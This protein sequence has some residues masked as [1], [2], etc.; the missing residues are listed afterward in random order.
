[1]NNEIKPFAAFTYKAP[2]GEIDTAT[3]NNNI[4]TLANDKNT[5]S[6]AELKDFKKEFA[7]TAQQLENTPLKDEVSFNKNEEAVINQK[8]QYKKPNIGT[9]IAGILAGR[10]VN[11]LTTN[12]PKNIISSKAFEE[13]AKLSDGLSK[14]EYEKI[15]DTLKE[16][17]KSS[18]LADKGVSL[19]KATA[20]N[21][22]EIEQIMVGEIDNGFLKYLPKKFKELLGGVFGSQIC[23]GENACYAFASKKII[24]PEKELGLAM[25]HEM[26]HA[27]NANLSKVGKMLQKSRGLSL[28]AIPIS[29]IA[30]FKTKKAPNEEPK[31]KIDKATTFI[32]N[33]AGKL[34]FA[35]FLPVLIEEGLA[36]IKGNK[37]AKQM[38]SP[39]LAKKVAKT[40]ALGYSTY[41]ALAVLSGLGIY[42]GTKVKDAIAK[43]KPIENKE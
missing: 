31:N 42:L 12:L 37:I 27:M 40:N 15:E 30:L 22:D 34:T 11:S 39:E 16:T 41:L 25:F 1:M 29:L 2:D 36:T 8:Q 7:A 18:G 17:I 21:A 13:M 32:K 38:L 14:N 6:Q 9:I 10:T 4:S 20:E 24:M 43:P 23:S 33:N 5:T 3:K 26:G 35:T 19:L 28:L